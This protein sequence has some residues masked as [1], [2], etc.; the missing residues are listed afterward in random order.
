MGLY[1]GRRGGAGAPRRAEPPPSSA[2]LAR[3]QG[4]ESS[5]SWGPGGPPAGAATIYIP[6]SGRMG[7]TS[8][9]VK[10][11]R[12]AFESQVRSWSSAEPRMSFRMPQMPVSPF[13]MPLCLRA[14][15]RWQSEPDRHIEGDARARPASF[16]CG[17]GMIL[18]I[19]LAARLDAG[20]VL[21]VAAW[22]SY[23]S[24]PAG[25]KKVW[26]VVVIPSTMPERD[27]PWQWVCG[28][29]GKHAGNLGGMVTLLMVTP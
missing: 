1:Q 25:V 11:G 7:N 14:F 17:S 5:R 16:P 15:S 13:W 4:C 20:T 29:R 21:W 27:R 23:H 8:L 19:A 12:R 26:T 6:G 24:L 9:D 2:A 3:V 22:P 10:A 18:P 28:G